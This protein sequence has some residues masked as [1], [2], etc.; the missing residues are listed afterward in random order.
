MRTVTVTGRGAARAVP[1]SAVVRLAAT[2]RAVGLG[3]ALAGAE[4]TRA[5][6]VSAAGGLTV[7]SQDLSVWPA[8]DDQGRPAGFEARHALVVSCPGLDRASELL[9]RLAAEVGDRLTVDGVQLEVSDTTTGRTAAREAAMADAR[10]R[11]EHLAGLAGATLGEVQRVVED[12]PAGPGPALH[13]LAA[14]KTDVA[15]EPGETTVTAA[16]TVTFALDAG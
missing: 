11:A 14:A 13:E 5:A 16:V 2:H 8:R 6:I 3:D 10:A 7:G 4:S 15:L 12:A 9:T 1:D